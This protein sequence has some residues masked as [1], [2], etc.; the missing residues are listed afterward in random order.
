MM[1]MIAGLETPT[2]GEIYFDEERVTDLPPSERNISMVFQFPAVYPALTVYENIALPLRAEKL[3]REEIRK[4]VLRVAD[5][6]GLKEYLD[7]KHHQLDMGILQKVAIAK[8]IVRNSRVFIL[9]EPLS[10]LDAKTREVLRGQIK[11]I[12]AEVEQTMIYVTHDQLDAM[13]LA[14]RIAV[15]KDGILQQFDTP[16]NIYHHPA[17]KFVA[18]FI[19]TPSINFIDST[20]HISSNYSYAEFGGQRLD[21]TSIND[22]LMEKIGEGVH[23]FTLG[24]RPQFIQVSLEEKPSSLKGIVEVVQNIGASTI[25]EVKVD[26]LILRALYKGV[27]PNKE[28]TVV[29][30]T[31]EPGNVRIINKKTEAVIL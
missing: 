20:I 15:L 23:D 9:D 18:F 22:V 7:Y 3:S 16:H 13:T 5:L 26:N 25:V 29:W 8:A 27:F 1:R 6:L 24:I 2:E 12:H 31:I 30:L 4:R 11:K 28:G 19:G 14:D 17:N 10:N 21:L